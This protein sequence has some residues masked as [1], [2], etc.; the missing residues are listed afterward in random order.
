MLRCLGELHVVILGRM[1]LSLILCAG[2]TIIC[3][4]VFHAGLKA[5]AGFEATGPVGDVLARGMVRHG[6]VTERKRNSP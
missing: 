6:F 3:L 5:T 1:R 2:T 4:L